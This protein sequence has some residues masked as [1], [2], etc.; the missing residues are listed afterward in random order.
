MRRENG[1][2]V[3]HKEV[4]ILIT[5]ALLLQGF[6]CLSASNLGYESMMDYY[7][8]QVVDNPSEYNLVCVAKNT[9][10][11]DMDGKKLSGVKK[12]DSLLIY[13]YQRGDKW[14]NVL[15]YNATYGGDPEKSGKVLASRLKKDDDGKVIVKAF[16]YSHMT[17]QGK[18]L[19]KSYYL[20]EKPDISSSRVG[21]LRSRICLPVV[22]LDN[23]EEYKYDY[24]SVMTFDGIGYIRIARII[25]SP[26]EI[27]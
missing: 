2:K 6:C 12:G 13:N 3:K 25:E 7:N 24:V 14:V 4:F 23:Y 11:Y 5:V 21:V 27:S 9:M 16:T 15:L 20:F 26:D 1:L 22:Y 19:E 10:L 17:V 8:L 18:N